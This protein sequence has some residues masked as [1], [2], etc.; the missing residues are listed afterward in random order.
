MG[1]GI[2]FAACWLTAVCLLFATLTIAGSSEK[3]AA[4]PVFHCALDQQSPIRIKDCISP[5][6]DRNQVMTFAYGRLLRQ[7][8]RNVLEIFPVNVF[9]Q[10][11]LLSLFGAKNLIVKDRRFRRAR[12]RISQLLPNLLGGSNKIT[13]L[14]V[15]KILEYK[16]I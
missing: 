13:I 9:I 6:Q 11:N 5:G 1:I 10:E 3:E 12:D 7:P 16:S 4:L 15:L 8:P 14:T 2:I